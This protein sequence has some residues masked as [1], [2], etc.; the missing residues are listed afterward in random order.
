MNWD[1]SGGRV[2][3]SEKKKNQND[4]YYQYKCGKRECK[5]S[6]VVQKTLFLVY[7]YSYSKNELIYACTTC[8]LTTFSG[9]LVPVNGW[10]ISPTIN[11]SRTKPRAAPSCKLW[12]LGIKLPNL[13]VER[14]LNGKAIKED[15]QFTE[16]Q[17][18]VPSMK[19]LLYKALQPTFL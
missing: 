14:E 2:N 1:A 3:I 11:A 8:L 16:I 4:I 15:S 12:K 5:Y 18:H 19:T 13:H 17:V 6:D 9:I 10:L 7:M